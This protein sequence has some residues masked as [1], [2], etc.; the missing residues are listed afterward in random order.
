[1]RQLTGRAAA[2][3]APGKGKARLT[4]EPDFRKQQKIY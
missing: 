3:D 4:D 2:A 1:M